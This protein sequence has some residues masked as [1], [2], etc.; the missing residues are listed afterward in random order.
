MR[1]GCEQNRVRYGGEE[2]GVRGERKSVVRR[3]DGKGKNKIIQKLKLY[4]QYA[5]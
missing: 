1:K 5:S 3:R 4:T 2:R